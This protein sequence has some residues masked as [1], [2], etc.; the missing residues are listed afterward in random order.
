MG[1]VADPEGHFRIYILD[2]YWVSTGII[3]EPSCFLLQT[4]TSV[5]LSL[6]GQKRDAAF[7]LSFP[8]LQQQNVV[9]DKLLQIVSASS[10][11]YWVDIV[12]TPGS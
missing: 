10:Y 2:W 12:F 3:K 11:V 6:F 1:F 8:D 4:I 7:E 5:Y 9:Y